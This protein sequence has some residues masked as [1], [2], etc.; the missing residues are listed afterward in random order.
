MKVITLN[1]VDIIQIK[2]KLTNYING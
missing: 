2:M 1:I